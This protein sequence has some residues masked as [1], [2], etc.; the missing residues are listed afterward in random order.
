MTD[1]WHFQH[2]GK[3]VAVLHEA[4]E[5]EKSEEPRLGTCRCWRTRSS[6][7]LVL[8]SQANFRETTAKTEDIREQ[9]NFHQLSS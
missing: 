9:L 3:S 6:A 5:I 4:A 8:F 1:R 2:S 7:G